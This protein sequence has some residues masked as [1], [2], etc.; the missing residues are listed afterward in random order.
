MNLDQKENSLCYSI[1]PNRP[2]LSEV[3]L[4]E[5]SVWCL[6]VEWSIPKELAAL[7]K[8]LDTSITSSEENTEE[9]T[10]KVTMRYDENRA[11]LKD[12]ID[13][14]LINFEEIWLHMRKNAET[15]G[16]L[17]ESVSNSTATTVDEKQVTKK[18]LSRQFRML[19]KKLKEIESS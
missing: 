12:R 18:N 5:F 11:F 3:R 16:Y 10:V 8:K 9:T 14:G 2:N 13:E 15:K 7:A 19:L 6:S 17:F 1:N 4:S